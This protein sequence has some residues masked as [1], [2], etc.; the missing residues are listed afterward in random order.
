MKKFGFVS[1]LGLP[2]AGKSTLV[3]ALVGS[4]VSIVSNKPQTTRCRILGIA[5]NDEAQIILMDAPGIFAPRRTLDKAMVDAAWGT[6]EECDVVIHIVDATNNRALDHNKI[7]I[8]RLDP[9]KPTILIL[10]KTD[11]AN[12]GDLL[13]QAEA[14]N[15]SF[16]Y[17]SILM[18]SA[19]NKDRV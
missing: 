15:K 16:S 12:K 7:I 2:N 1:I 9:K 19:L 6:L 17:H 18:I 13:T 4:K 10:N 5:M 14:F 8:D 3:N 11:Q